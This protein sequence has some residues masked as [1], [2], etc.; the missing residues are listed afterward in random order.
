ME[1]RSV[2]K[3][4]FGVAQ[5]KSNSRRL[6]TFGGKPR[7]IK[8]KA[9]IQFEKDVKAQIGKMDNM[10]E[11]DLSFHADIYYPTRR[12]DLDPSILLDAMQGLLYEN[13]RQFKQI[14]SRRF[15]DKEN[16]RA[17]ITITEIDHNEIGPSP[18]TGRDDEP[19]FATKES[20]CCDES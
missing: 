19:S 14:S 13:D 5:S 11:G 7:F 12:Q 16:P 15:L 8:S 4:I 17:E 6:V 1:K 20:T 9:A 3:I 10:L 2:N 18:Q